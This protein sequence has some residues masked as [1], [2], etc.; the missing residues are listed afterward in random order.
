MCYSIAAENHFPCHC[1][2]ATV[3]TQPK[4]NKFRC[5]RYCLNKH[6][7]VPLLY[8]VPQCLCVS[9]CVWRTQR[10]RKYKHTDK[11]EELTA[12]E[13][14]CVHNPIHA[15]THTRTINYC[16]HASSVRFVSFH[17]VL[18]F[19]NRSFGQNWTKKSRITLKYKRCYFFFDAN[20]RKMIRQRRKSAVD[21]ENR[22]RENDSPT[23]TGLDSH[24]DIL[25]WTTIKWKKFLMCA[26]ILSISISM[27][28]SQFSDRNWPNENS[29]DDFEENPP[30][31]RTTA[32]RKRRATSKPGEIRI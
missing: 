9:E 25:L 7:H 32:N 10:M 27:P 30:W 6:D 31:S 3:R 14:I 16:F 13:L 5:A 12:V 26:L 11:R 8:F 29:D 4:T 23:H 18:L 1:S 22:R 2:H 20:H 21:G 19:D 24:N 17:F 15:H 28:I